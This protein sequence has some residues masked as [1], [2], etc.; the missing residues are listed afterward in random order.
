M[1]MSDVPELQTALASD[2]TLT[3]KLEECLAPVRAHEDASLI[4]VFEVSS[5][6]LKHIMT[7]G[8][9][10]GPHVQCIVNTISKRP[11]PPLPS[12]KRAS[13]QLVLTWS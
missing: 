10:L 5:G 8:K 2:A 9:P 7:Q 1:V 13:L 12:K 4:L 11:L 6:G 3:P